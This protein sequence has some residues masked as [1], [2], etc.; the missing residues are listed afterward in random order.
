MRTTITVNDDLWER[1]CDITGIRESSELVRK[2]LRE[3]V[4]QEAAR[5]L[6]ALG[7][8]MPGAWAPGR[9]RGDDWTAKS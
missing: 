3:M 9:S 7:G 5:R 1:A 8:A 6:L 2:A 4:A